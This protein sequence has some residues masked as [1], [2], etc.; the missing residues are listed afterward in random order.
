MGKVEI[1]IRKKILTPDNL[2][3][4][5]NYP[6]LL[7]KYERHKRFKRA[8]RIFLYSLALTAF[9][10]SLIFVSVWKIMLDQNHKAAGIQQGQLT[11]LK[12]NGPVTDTISL[13]LL[14]NQATDSMYQVVY[15]GTYGRPDDVFKFPKDAYSNGKTSYR[16]V[17]EKKVV[18]GDHEYIVKKYIYDVPHP[19]N[20]AYYFYC[21][22]FAILIF[23]SSWHENYYLQ[24]IG[25]TDTNKTL[26]LLIE[27]V[28]ADP[29]FN[30]W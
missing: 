30:Y 15:K 25:N 23:A 19:A 18:I 27:A 17:G 21:P 11:Y 8:V 26:H 9:V 28:K 14:S 4:Y 2:T 7:K 22:E 13:Q 12:T 3:Q 29:E 1:K 16:Y 10:L 6:A 5:R 24:D 20:R